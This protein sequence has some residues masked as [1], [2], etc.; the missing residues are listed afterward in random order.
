DLPDISYTVTDGAGDTQ[1]STI[2]INVTPVSDLTDDS[3]TISVQ[4]DTPTSG[5]VLDNASSPD[6]PLTITSVVIGGVEVAVGVTTQLDEGE[7]TLN[8]DG[9]Y[10]FVPADNFNGDLPEI[11]Y[12]VTDGAGDTQTST[13]SISVT[14]VSDLTD[15]SETISVQE[16]TPTSGNVLDNASSPDGPLTI[17]SVVIGGV[18]VAVGVTTQL[19]EGEFTLNEDGSYTFVPADNFNGDLP[20]ISYTVTDGAGDTQTSTISISV[21][22]VSD[23]TDDSETISVQEDT[24]TSGNVLDNATTADADGPVTVV[25]FVIGNDTYLAGETAQLAEGDFTL[26]ADGTYTFVPADDYNGDVP[27]ISYNIQDAAGDTQTSTLNIRVSPISDLV[28]A[29]ESITIDE[30]ETATGSVL[31]NATTADGDGPVTVVSFVIGNDTYLAGETTQLAEG[32]FTLNADGTYTFVPTEDYN[33]DVPV[34]SYNIQDAAGDEL[35]STLTID[36]TSTSDLV[37]ANESITINED[38]TASGSV[39][40]NATTANGDGP[41]TVVSFVIGNETYLAGETAQ[42]AEGDFTLNADGTYTF[43]P[44]AD[45][46][47]DVPV[48]SY[49]IQDAAGDTQTST[50]N[51]RVSP[52]SDLV[53]ANESITI[54]EDE[55]ASGSVLD[56]A[57][58][59]NGDGPVTVVSFVIGNETYLA[60]ETAQLAEGDFT[61][62]ADGTYTFVPA[63]DYNGDVPVISYN[64]QDAAGDTQ[65]ST[66][67]IRV[68]PISDLVDAN[69][70]ITID[71]DET[72]TG[73]VLDNAS[74]ADGDGPVT[75]VSFVIGNETY[76]AGET[77]QLAEGDFTL[78]ADGIYTFVPAE[79]YNGDV[80]VISYNIQDAAGDELTSTLTI[81]I[82]PTSD[83]VDAN[84]SITIDEDETATGSVLDNATTTDGDGPV[85]VVSFVIGN[86]TY[87]A[88]E[89]AQLAEGDFTLNAD[90]TYTFVPADDYNGDVPVISY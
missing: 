68:S 12:T 85:T 52:I 39:L 79:D 53:D 48:I 90:G 26:N 24:P 42:L 22:P 21:T 38:E 36:I 65:T 51:I 6:G 50:L 2:S 29:N 16:D 64:I 7:F 82:T 27:V 37:D 23:L 86:D 13:I 44:A 78:N 49:N 9:S 45:Y 25:S 8:E 4:E 10:T 31:D 17:T 66:L 83:L 58:T 74:T 43:V 40:D 88:G 14:P 47:G 69:E 18:E 70:S 3:E 55:T 80:P 1:T 84:E 73:S 11:S 46:N 35:T 77:A 76:L 34:I 71:E 75:V 59:A 28:D 62:N 5:N 61:L 32:D 54:D 72:A 67:N 30:D 56:N 57:T 15:D 81:D 60:G 89:T 41:V 33:G 87:L 19:D 63:D 20:D